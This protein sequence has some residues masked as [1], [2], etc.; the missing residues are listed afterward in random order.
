MELSFKH[1]TILVTGATRGIGKQIAND[2]GS[3]GASL[4]LT[5][6]H[7]DEIEELNRKAIAE[8]TGK[9]YFY[10]DL[11]KHESLAK[12]LA[13]LEEIPVIDGLVNNAGINRLN[14]LQDV[15]LQDWDDMLAV[16]LT[17]PFQIIRGVSKKMIA[18]GYGRIVNVG[19]IFSKI[20]KEKRSVYSATKFG[21]HGLTVGASN[22]LARYNVLINTLSPGFIMT[23][24]T[25]KNLSEKE[26]ADLKNMIPAKR[27]G[28]VNDISNVA[29]FL[30]SELNQYLTGQ[31]I[32]VDGGFTNV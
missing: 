12:F 9:R 32:I 1:R 25:K 15:V 29:V 13:D 3:L 7:A 8:N 21:I 10:L 4:L 23:E 24:L 20:S 30:M 5:G 2:L 18:N 28:T 6:T 22:D 27:L 17:A 11:M 26:M 14:A 16:N 31:N 19:S